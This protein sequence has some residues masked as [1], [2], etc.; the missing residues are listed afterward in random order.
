MPLCVKIVIVK[1]GRR[2]MAFSVL[3]TIAETTLKF[4]FADNVL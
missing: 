2:K 3:S 4:S 1:F